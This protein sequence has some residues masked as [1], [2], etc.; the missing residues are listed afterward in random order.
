MPVHAGNRFYLN[1]PQPTPQIVYAGNEHSWYNE[2][3]STSTLALYGID[4]EGK[5]KYR[6][7]YNLYSDFSPDVLPDGRIVFSSWQPSGEGKL[8]LMFFKA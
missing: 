6:L 7:T 2:L 3:E 4:L 1:D 8:A 5:Q